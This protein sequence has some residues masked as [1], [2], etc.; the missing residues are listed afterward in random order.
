MFFSRSVVPSQLRQFCTF[1]EFGIPSPCTQRSHDAE[2][3]TRPV[4]P[5]A[6][7]HRRTHTMQV[8]PN[9]TIIGSE[10]ASWALVRGIRL[11]PFC[12]F[13]SAQTFFHDRRRTFLVSP[14]SIE[15]EPFSFC[16]FFCI[17]SCVCFCDRVAA[18]PGKKNFSCRCVPPW[19]LRCIPT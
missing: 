3:L 12:K 19:G 10:G 4:A 11:C 5:Q 14:D 15:L 7:T 1:E 9:N 8:H 16:P 6:Q 18:V 2:P 17:F 13:G